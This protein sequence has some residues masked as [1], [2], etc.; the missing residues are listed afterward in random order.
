MELV[1]R[2]TL[3]D[4]IAQGAI[5]LADALPIAGSENGSWTLPGEAANMVYRLLL[6]PD[7]I[8]FAK[9][10]VVTLNG[11]PAFSGAVTKDVGALLRWSARDNDRT[12]LYGA[13][14]NVVVP[15]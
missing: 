9:P 14:L 7:A 12:M 13:E 5:P 2:P 10:V 11:K 1:E 6:S 3:A 4:R 15:C 8:D